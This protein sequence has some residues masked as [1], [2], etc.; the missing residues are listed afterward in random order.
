MSIWYNN[1]NNKKLCTQLIYYLMRAYF[2]YLII[3]RWYSMRLRRY[4]SVIQ[5][6]SIIDVNPYRLIFNSHGHSYNMNRLTAFQFLFV[7][8]T[9]YNL[10]ILY[11]NKTRYEKIKVNTYYYLDNTQWKKF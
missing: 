7:G 10:R 6:D 11:I 1:N 3:S 5:I 4:L 9:T 8:F 2:H